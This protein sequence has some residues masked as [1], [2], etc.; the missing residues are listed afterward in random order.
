MNARTNPFSHYSALFCAIALLLLCACLFAQ[1]QTVSRA[2]TVLDS[3]P[4]AKRIGQVALS[5]DG[6]QVAYFAD[7]KLAIIP[8]GGGPSQAIAVEG[9]LPLRDVTWSADSKR[10][11]FIAGTEVRVRAEERLLAE[12]FGDSFTACRTRVRAFIPFIR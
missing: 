7:R 11:A 3:M 12:R 10:I 9:N 5:P 8:A 4:H 1:D 2:A 6:T